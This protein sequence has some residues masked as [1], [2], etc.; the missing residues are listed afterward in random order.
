M[1][2]WNAKR[3]AAMVG[4]VLLVLLYVVTFLVAIFDRESSG[5]LFKAC[6]IATIGIPILLWV[7]I[8]LFGQLTGKR[9]IATIEAE[10]KDAETE[11]NSGKES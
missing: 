6:L 2:K 3:I 1:K 10:Q 8:W 11:E 4:V 7:Y 9:T 5:Q